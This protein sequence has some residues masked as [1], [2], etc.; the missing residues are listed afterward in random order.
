MLTEVRQVLQVIDHCAVFILIAGTYTPICAII[1]ASRSG[2]I[3][4]QVVTYIFLGTHGIENRVV[5]V[6]F[7]DYSAYSILALA[8][9]GEKHGL[10]FP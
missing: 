4:I 5:Y 1:A 9:L 10:C 2:E 8:S 7:R 3:V 6:F